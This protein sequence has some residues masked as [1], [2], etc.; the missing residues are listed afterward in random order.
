MLTATLR[1]VGGSVMLSVPP[2][3]LEALHLF[4]G[5]T[6]GLCVE[7]GRQIIQPQPRRGYRL[8]DLLAQCDPSAEPPDDRAWLEA[9]ATSGGKLARV[10]GRAV[11]LAGAGAEMPGIVRCDQP[12]ALDHAAR[13]APRR[14]WWRS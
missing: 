11:S 5:A 12:C 6:V 8:A 10:S 2:S 7:H 1:K 3:I 14:R 9:P 13:H 4:T